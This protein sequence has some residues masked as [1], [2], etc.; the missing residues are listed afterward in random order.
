MRLTLKGLI[1][2]L[3]LFSCF[4]AYAEVPKL[5]LSRPHHYTTQQGMVFDKVN[6]FA[7]DKAGFIW[8]ATEDGL[9][10]FDGKTFRNIKYDTQRINGLAG[11]YITQMHTDG[12]G[13]M[14]VTSRNGISK[15]DNSSE[16][17]V[18]HQLL[19]TSKG[20]YKT[21]VSSISRSRED[22]ELWISAN[23]LG[24]F[25]FNTLSGDFKRYTSESLPG[26]RSNMVTR[27]LQDSRGL[28]WIG[29]QDAGLQVFDMTNGELS[30]YEPLKKLQHEN[31]YAR[32]HHIYEDAGKRIWVA[33][34]NGLL[35][36]D[37]KTG[38]RHWFTADEL[39]LPSNRFRAIVS[40]NMHEIYIGLEDGGVY[41]FSIVQKQGLTVLSRMPAVSDPNQPAALTNRSVSSL[42]FD[43]DGNLW[44]GTTGDGVFLLPRPK[45]NFE[46]L[47]HV[48]PLPAAERNSIRYYGLSEDAEGNLFVGTD[49]H[50]IFVLDGSNR[51]VGHYLADDRPGSIMDNAIL[52]AY[53]DSRDR[54]W[55]GSYN[56]GLSMYRK[57]TGDFQSYRFSPDEEGSLG[58]DDVR[59]IFEDSRRR[60][61]IGSNGGG[62]NRLHE[63]TGKFS[64]YLHTNSDIPSNDIRAI[65]EDLQGNL[66]IGTYGAGMTYFNPEREQFIPFTANPA[67]GGL[68]NEVIYALHVATGGKL[69]IATESLGLLV[70]DLHTHRIIKHYNERN[71]LASNTVFSIKFDLDSSCWV[72]TNNGLSK[73]DQRTGAITNYSSSSG[74]QAGIFNPGSAHFSLRR[75][76]LFFG[77]TAGL[78]YFNPRK[79]TSGMPP[80][81]VMLT[82]L[83]IFGERIDA[84]DPCGQPILPQALNETS[85]LTLKPFQSTFTIHYSSLE[86]GYADEV[87]YAYKLDGLDADWNFVKGQQPATYRYLPPG[88]YTFSVGIKSGSD[89]LEGSVKTLKVIVLPPWYKN[90]WAYLGYLL[91]ACTVIY[92]YLRYRRQQERLKYELAI[93]RIER[94]KEKEWNELKMNFYTRL[95][96]E[97]RS[98]LTLILNPVKDLLN[99]GPPPQLEPYV[100][101]LHANTSRLLRLA[102]QAL[103]IRKDDLITEKVMWEEL[104]VVQLANDV[105]AC[106]TNQTNRKKI[107]M[108]LL[109]DEE[110]FLIR[111]DREKLEIVVFNLL[112]N[113]VKF[114]DQGEVCMSIK[115]IHN[116][117][118]EIA[119]A[120]TGCGIPDSVGPRLFE[121]FYQGT[122][123]DGHIPKGFG[124]GLWMV[125]SLIEL[126]GGK[127]NYR[128]ERGQGTTFTILLPQDLPIPPAADKPPENN[129]S[130]NDMA[131]KI[132]EMPKPTKILIVEDDIELAGYLKVLFEADYGVMLTDNEADALEIVGAELPD[133]IVCDIMLTD[134]NG[135]DFCRMVKQT[136]SWKH[137]PILLITATKGAQIQ[138]E[139]MENGADD[140]L[141]KP[142]DKD[143]LLAKVRALLKRAAN[144]REYFFNSLT[145]TVGHQKLSG[146]DKTL[147]DKCV[148]IIE[149][150]LEDDD[151][152]VH[153]LADRCGMTYATLS[154]RIKEINRQTLNSL[155]R[156]VRLHR[157]AQLLLTTDNAVYEVAYK[158]GMKDVK[159]F[160]EQ[161]VKLYKLNP[162]EFVRKY[163]KPFHEIHRAN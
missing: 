62:L 144:L 39:G 4:G 111:A 76:L 120:D 16:S 152:N 26:L 96:H 86:Y 1:T 153:V 65:A 38:Y 81:P 142:F 19:A 141:A 66:I 8:I 119:V 158:V 70:Y 55:F 163:R 11:N 112:F 149:A 75:G 103:N 9:S 104:D 115:R 114:T 20:R 64:R 33:T 107:S 102:D 52:Y 157:A 85:T 134:G 35:L 132:L 93:S 73:I 67:D 49:G 24:L 72:S 118:L 43:R 138:L 56:G 133:I 147:L 78:T 98:S 36:V 68:A 143:V 58:G 15:Y 48:G 146:E 6:S 89:V 95:S 59:V 32:V 21:D 101:T 94:E 140:F 126:H 139:G 105:M 28:V 22:N 46:N 130:G 122:A 80:K 17:F 12:Q 2:G 83:E 154:N 50:G 156:T 124:I 79:L 137:I 160:R 106:F 74:I 108:T 162:S 99:S 110:H 18:H 116:K 155:I 97:F 61:W 29:T 125:K 23:G 82:A 121:Q 161:F 30:L 10:R 13:N 77:G 71:G 3:L 92:Y 41:R 31:S 135:I 84:G 136:V 7:Q 127:I 42:F 57:A 54:M 27:I 131:R 45:Y 40:R 145:D 117:L 91:A 129:V 100:N 151:F 14:W 128:S 123:S 109:A 150:H 90:G 60:L 87:D 34:N 47:R 5:S 37:P 51:L 113:A 148:S 69:W 159:Y 88:H 44:I 53:R 63:A 25:R